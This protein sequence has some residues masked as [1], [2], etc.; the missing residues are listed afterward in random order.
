MQEGALQPGDIDKK[1][2]KHLAAMPSNLAIEALNK[3]RSSNLSYVHN[4][5][6]YLQGIIRHASSHLSMATAFVD[7]PASAF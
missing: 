4:V 6:A 2:K 7:Q 3:L 1:A 5:P